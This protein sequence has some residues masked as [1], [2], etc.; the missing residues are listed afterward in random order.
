MIYVT[1]DQIEAMTLAD[2]I[3][4]IASRIRR[5]HACGAFERPICVVAF[6]GS[7]K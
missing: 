3:V 5:W 6:L 2:R 4:M 1:H 7:R